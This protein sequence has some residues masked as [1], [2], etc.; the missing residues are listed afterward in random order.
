MA[1]CAVAKKLERSDNEGPLK[2]DDAA[3]HPEEDKLDR[4]SSIDYAG[5]FAAFMD[6]VN[7]GF[8][9]DT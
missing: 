6:K 2:T 7:K 8:L 3:D 9:L 5:D 1:R 4:E